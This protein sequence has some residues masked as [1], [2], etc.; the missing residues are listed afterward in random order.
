M[1]VQRSSE[2]PADVRRR[3]ILARLQRVDD[4]RRKELATLA[5]GVHAAV[6]LAAV[7]GAKQHDRSW[8]MG[9][10]FRMR[11]WS[12]AED[13]RGGVAARAALRCVVA[14]AVERVTHRAFCRNLVRVDRIV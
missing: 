11:V 8:R 13:M 1:G 6:E 14:F 2:L 10:S 7:D 4:V 5:P 9:W 3:P 12:D